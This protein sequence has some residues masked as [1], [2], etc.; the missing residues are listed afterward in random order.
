MLVEA[1]DKC[2]SAVEV[3]FGTPD[4]SAFTIFSTMS[5]YSVPESGSGIAG[6]TFEGVFETE[7]VP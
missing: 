4:K 6:K 7:A 5:G 2:V 3:G 1:S